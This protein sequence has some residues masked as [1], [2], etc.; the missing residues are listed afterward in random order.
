MTAN[1]PEKAAKPPRKIIGASTVQSNHRLT[2]AKTVR[3]KLNAEIGDVVV[4]AE[5][6]E[7]N[8]FL[9]IIKK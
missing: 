8:L 6:E 3:E 5:D 1:P 2:L 7:G 9:K 4:F